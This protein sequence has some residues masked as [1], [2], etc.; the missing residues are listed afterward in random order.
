MYGK[1]RHTIHTMDK[2]IKINKQHWIGEQEGAENKV[3]M[4]A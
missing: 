4:M 2:V 1:Q 3:G